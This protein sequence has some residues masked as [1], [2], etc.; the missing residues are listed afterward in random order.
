M[1]HRVLHVLGCG[2][3]VFDLVTFHSSVVRSSLLGIRAE[4]WN[5]LVVRHGILLERNLEL[6]VWPLRY[7][8]SLFASCAHSQCVR[9]KRSV[10]PTG[11]GEGRRRVFACPQILLYKRV[12]LC[13]QYVLSGLFAASGAWPCLRQ[14][15]WRA[16]EQG[17]TFLHRQMLRLRL[18]ADQHWSR[19][20]LFCR[21]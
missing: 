6:P 12:A 21:W 18:P 2:M 7:T 3:S 4:A 13:R 10:L 5:L 1:H 17:I 19:D 15:A 9:K 14:G 11:L 16:L 8:V 20:A